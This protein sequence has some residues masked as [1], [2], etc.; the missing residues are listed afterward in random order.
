MPWADAALHLALDVVRVDRLA[1]VLD[2]G[3]AQDL[4]VAGLA[5][6]LDVADVG[7]EAGPAPSALTSWWPAIGPPV[8]ARLGGD[9]GE[10]QRLELAGV[11]RRPAWRCAVLPDHRLRVDAPHLR[12]ALAQALR[13]PARPPGSS[14]CPTAKVTRLPPVDVVVAERGGVGD[15]GAHLLVGDAEHLGR[16]QRHRGARCRRCRACRRRAPT[17]P[18]S[19]TFSASQVSPPKLNQKPQA[20]PRPWFG[21]SGAF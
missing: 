8:L 14:P 2:R 19:L 12:G 20:T 16:H 6:D 4:D 10:R 3:V 1:G 21:P 9:L 15:D 7:A 13:S 17:V 11:R 5:V 18:S